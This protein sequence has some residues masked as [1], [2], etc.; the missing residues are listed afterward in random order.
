[1]TFGGRISAELKR[2][3][4]VNEIVHASNGFAVNDGPAHA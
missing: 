3:A 1:V 4:G 2:G